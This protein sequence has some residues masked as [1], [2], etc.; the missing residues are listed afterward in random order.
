MTIPKKLLK[1]W[2]IELKGYGIIR[3]AQEMNLNYRTVR[4]AIK[5]GSCTQNVY[6]K[7]NDYL[8]AKRIE[9]KSKA[10]KVLTELD[11]D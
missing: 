2:E 6:D 9:I 7:I 4:S 1:N 11:Q 10:D 3:S 8:I 5:T